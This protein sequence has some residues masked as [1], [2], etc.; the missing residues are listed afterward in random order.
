MLVQLAAKY[1]ARVTPSWQRAKARGRYET[2]TVRHLC[3]ANLETAYEIAY[4]R[5]A[6]KG[7]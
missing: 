7:T 1:D 4:C 6:E 3:K 2:C 5:L